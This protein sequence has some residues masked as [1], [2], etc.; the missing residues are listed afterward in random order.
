MTATASTPILTKNYTD[1]NK[2]NALISLGDISFLGK[3]TSP[4][5]IAQ[6]H[7]FNALHSDYFRNLSEKEQEKKLTEFYRP[8]S[9]PTGGTGNRPRWKPTSSAS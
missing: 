3:E 1:E 7:S 8:H 4:A 5:P 2:A 9:R 6:E